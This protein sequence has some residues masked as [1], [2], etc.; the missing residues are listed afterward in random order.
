MTEQFVTCRE[1][2]ELLGLTPR[3]VLARARAGTLPS[4]DLHGAVRFRMSEIEEYAAG[5]KRQVA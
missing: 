4:Y 5:R 1:V 2:A 3:Q